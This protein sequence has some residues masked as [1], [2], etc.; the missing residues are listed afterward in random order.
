MRRRKTCRVCGE[1]NPRWRSESKCEAC[2]APDSTEI[3]QSARAKIAGLS[4]QD[5]AT[6]ASDTLEDTA[7]PG[8]VAMDAAT[9]AA[10]SARVYAIAARLLEINPRKP[11]GVFGLPFEITPEQAPDKWRRRVA[12]EAS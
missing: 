9:E 10:V 5:M 2:D 8:G 1:Q 4:K 7:T 11:V 3:R 12:S 6:V